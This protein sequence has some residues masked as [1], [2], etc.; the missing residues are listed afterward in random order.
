LEQEW[1]K[2]RK[3]QEWNEDKKGDLES[4]SRV[5]KKKTYGEQE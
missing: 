1:T 4:K 5:R 2:E 3:E